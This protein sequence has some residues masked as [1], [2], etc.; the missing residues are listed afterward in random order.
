MCTL[1]VA[2]GVHPRHP[3]LVAS[4]RD[5]AHERP[6]APADFWSD[7]PRVLAGRDLR[8]GGTWHGVTTGGRWAAVT[9]VRAPEWMH[10]TFPRS[11]GSLVAGYLCGDETPSDFAARA[12]AER[13]TYGGF[14]LLVGNRNGLWFASSRWPAPRALGPGFYGLSNGTLDE[15]WPKVARGGRAFQQWVEGGASDEDALFEIMRDETPAP[16]DRLPE[17]GVG[18]EKERIL[19]PLFISGSAYGTRTTTLLTVRADGGVRFAE[20]SFAPNGVAAGTASHD[21][22]IG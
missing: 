5:E 16:D 2:H 13:E 12:A 18:I 14:N 8:A 22:R 20:R 6:T 1:F 7:C 9:N 19:S 10:G 21:F 11:R 17:T 4:N 15:P 3:L